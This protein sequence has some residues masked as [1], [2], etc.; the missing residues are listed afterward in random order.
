MESSHTK[1]LIELAQSKGI[2]RPRDL[3]KIGV[4]RQYLSIA[5][6]QGKLERI[7]RGLYSLPGYMLTENRSLAEVC[8][9][10]PSGVIC[11]LSAL[12]YHGLNSQMPYEV[13]IALRGKA[14]IPKVERVQIRVFRLSGK[15][16]SEGVETHIE[17]GAEIR[18]YNPA[19]TVADCFK[20]RKKIGLDI[21]IDALRECV[22]KRQ[23]TIDEILEYGRICRIEQVMKPYLEAIQQYYK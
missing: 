4:P 22:H 6:R 12:Q 14:R 3:E 13:W 16:L 15:A 9:L 21:A 8:K 7:G 1:R 17:D 19:K 20:F 2:I 11:L 10:V 23:A 18:V 5:C